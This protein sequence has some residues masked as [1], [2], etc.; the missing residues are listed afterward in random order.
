MNLKKIEYDTVYIVHFRES[1]SSPQWE[2][3]WPT[4]QQADVRAFQIYTDGGIAIVVEQ[5]KPQSVQLIEQHA[6][7]LSPG[8]SDENE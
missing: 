2:E 1:P 8:V 5:Q 6:A 3:E 4:K 7:S